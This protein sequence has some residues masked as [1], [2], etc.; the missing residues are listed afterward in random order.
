[1]SN[2]VHRE[3]F[4]LLRIAT[5]QQRA[6]RSMRDLVDA[7]ERFVATVD[8]ACVD[9]KSELAQALARTQALQQSGADEHLRTQAALEHGGL[10]VMIA[11]RDRLL[12]GRRGVPQIDA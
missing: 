3:H 7:V 10:E 2:V 1:M 5:E 8:Q 6:A 9:A 11:E 4:L 12:A